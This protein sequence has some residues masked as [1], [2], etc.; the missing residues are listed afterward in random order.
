MPPQL[1]YEA[2]AADPQGTC[3]A[4][5]KP[6]QQICKAPDDL[7][8]FYFRSAGHAQLICKVPAVDSQGS[9]SVSATLR[10]QWLAMLLLD[11]PKPVGRLEISGCRHGGWQARMLT[12][13]LAVKLGMDWAESHRTEEI[14]PRPHEGNFQTVSIRSGW[15]ECCWI[16]KL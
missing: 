6:M 12:Q 2:P 11:G 14:N 4:T 16:G 9:C 3:S 1:I 5:A 7:H 15:T 8:D 13:T 10:L